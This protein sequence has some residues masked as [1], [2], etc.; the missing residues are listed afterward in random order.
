MENIRAERSGRSKNGRR[1]SI[2]ARFQNYAKL[3]EEQ[4]EVGD[5]PFQMPCS[6]RSSSNCKEEIFSLGEN[7]GQDDKGDVKDLLGSLSEDPGK[8]DKNLKVF[9]NC[10]FLKRLPTTPERPPV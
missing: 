9:L 1:S 4:S 8:S 2:L 3:D 7:S 10:L 5:S 6:S